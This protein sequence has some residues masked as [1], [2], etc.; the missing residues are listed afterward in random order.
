MGW[1]SRDFKIYKIEE[2][3]P[4]TNQKNTF[5]ATDKI[6][7][8]IPGYKLPQDFGCFFYSKTRKKINGTSLVN[9]HYQVFAESFRPERAELVNGVIEYASRL[10]QLRISPISFGTKIAQIKRFINWCDNNCVAGL[11]SRDNFLIAAHK[12]SEELIRSI[13]MSTLNVNTG[14][15]L[16]YIVLDLGRS[17]YGDP[18]GDLFRT[19][20]KIRKSYKAINTTEKPDDEKARN[21]LNIYKDLF[22][23]LSLF[24]LNFYGF[25]HKIHI[26]KN[27]YWFFPTTVPFA[28]PA[29]IHKKAALKDR[30]FVYDYINGK[31]RTKEEI[32]NLEIHKN[33]DFYGISIA[34]A[35]NI[36]KTANEDKHHNRRLMAA[37]LA[38]Q[39]FIMLFSAN[40]GM[41][42]SQISNLSWSGDYEIERDRQGFKT[43]KYR[44]N[45][46]IVTFYITNNFVKEFKKF[47]TL[48]SYVLECLNLSSFN[49]LFFTVVDRN[50]V[51][52]SMN[53][54]SNYNNRIKNCFNIDIKITTRMW[55]A[56][57]SD[58]LI[59]NS[60][61]NTTALILQNTSDTVIK[62]YATGSE[63]QASQE[64][65]RFLSNFKRSLIITE[66]TASVPIAI[67]QCIE[68]NPAPTQPDIPIMPDC[69][70]PEGCLFCDKYRLHCDSKDYKKLISFRY[71]LELS[72]SLSFSSDHYEKV[73]GPVITRIN[74]IEMQILK[75]KK[76]SDKAI[77][78]IRDDIYHQ[79]N[80]D[81]YWT[82]K[83]R[84]LDDLGLF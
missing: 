34:R 11:D 54:S 6:L 8:Q 21:A 30:Y 38:Y 44:A 14:A 66:D 67:G 26:D 45:G 3:E 42:L 15:S 2:L 48:R 65:S 70:L 27:Y 5:M 74:E 17:I 55:R 32:K 4:A 28:G 84:L 43:V 46:K 56:F 58:W 20:R 68:S 78:T 1:I 22:N 25:P 33:F 49:Y 80:L 76:L 53:T 61:I 39:S 77:R 47:I 10:Y 29:N 52:L 23:Q 12:Y 83:L 72:K 16:Q 36:I 50:V 19:I 7:L 79:E 71:I 51:Q 64:I 60:D 18:C 63:E 40:T 75:S 41:S 69:S 31:I 59:R 57:K 37:T 9:S 35:K 13:Q 24:V 62:H 81:A 82:K 73:I